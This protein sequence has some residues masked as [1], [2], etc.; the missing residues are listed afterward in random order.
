MRGTGR[1]VTGTEIANTDPDQPDWRL[2][3]RD[4]PGLP[5]RRDPGGRPYHSRCWVSGFRGRVPAA[6]SLPVLVPGWPD[7]TQPA[8]TLIA[9]CIGQMEEWG[10]SRQDADGELPVPGVFGVP[11]QWPH[12]R[13][14]YQRAGFA[15]TGHT[16][17]VYL[18]QVADLPRPESPIA[19]LSVRRSVG[20]NGTRLSAVLGKKTIGYIEVEVFEEGQ[21]LSRHRGWADIGNLHIAREYRRRRIATWLLGQAAD[22]LRLAQVQRLLDYAWLEGQDPTGQDY[23]DYKAFLTASGFG[24]LTRTQ[25][26][27]TRTPRNPR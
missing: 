6:V 25:R 8:E 18:A 2:A 14:L 21:R 27:W 22:W 4:R 5:D 15:H 7:A 17:V 23:D 20:I 19:G 10:V 26:G 12:I 16:E 1:H 13:G 3:G 11:E 24:E 9:A